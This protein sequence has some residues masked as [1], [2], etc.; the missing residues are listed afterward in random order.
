MFLSPV[1]P[2][3][4]AV[5]G[6][7]DDYRRFFFVRRASASAARRVCLA[8]RPGATSSTRP[9]GLS[10]APRFGTHR[11]SC[12]PG[13]RCPVRPPPLRDIIVIFFVFGF[14]ELGYIGGVVNRRGPAGEAGQRFAG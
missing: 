4:A 12:P 10:A 8:E 6:R 13:R 9:P 14:G 3:V 11:A 5:A 2:P 7:L 1:Y